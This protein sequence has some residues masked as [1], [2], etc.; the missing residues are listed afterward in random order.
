MGFAMGFD[1][2]PPL[3]PTV[4]N[5]EKYEQFIRMI[6]EHY[7]SA[8][9][10]G[11]LACSEEDR[12]A[13]II[14]TKNGA[15]IEF[16]VGERPR[17]PYVPHM[18]NHFLRFSSKVSGGSTARAEPFIRGVLRLARKV[19][20]DRVKPWHEVWDTEDGGETRVSWQ[21]KQI[22]AMN[23]KMMSIL[24]GGVELDPAM[25][26]LVEEIHD[27]EESEQWDR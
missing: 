7:G 9:G 23:K 5:Q 17:L 10:E 2:Y 8:D 4:R 21:W 20:G 11:E 18:C 19:F 13:T 15:Y 27:L 22:H 14:S 3:K 25:E 12:V 26:Q 1:I 24:D 6:L 16:G